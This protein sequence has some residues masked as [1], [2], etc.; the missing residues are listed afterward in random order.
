MVEEESELKMDV[1]GLS[2]LGRSR[3]EQQ[4]QNLVD[5]GLEQEFLLGLCDDSVRSQDL[6]CYWMPVL[7]SLRYLAN[8][9][10]GVRDAEGLSGLAVLQLG[11]HLPE[12]ASSCAEQWVMADHF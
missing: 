10:V 12:Y 1:V 11:Q 2:G 5:F 4:E 7:A 9:R 3:L 6:E 8:L